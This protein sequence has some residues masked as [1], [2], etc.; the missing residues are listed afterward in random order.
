MNYRVT[1]YY[2]DGQDFVAH[3]YNKDLDLNRNGTIVGVSLGD[4]VIM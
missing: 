3:H 2:R 1:N 4:E